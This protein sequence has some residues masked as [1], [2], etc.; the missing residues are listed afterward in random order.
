MMETTG[1]P[2]MP[3]FVF[4]RRRDVERE[5]GF[6]LA[7]QLIV[8]IPKGTNPKRRH[9]RMIDEILRQLTANAQSGQMPDDAIVY[10]WRGGC[11]PDDAVDVHNNALMKNWVS[12]RLVCAVR[13]DP[14]NDGYMRFDSDLLM[15]M[16]L[17][18]RHWA[19][20]K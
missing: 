4:I 15:K 1:Q 19:R 6:I 3:A 7:G 20:T 12:G 18:K 11:R 17:A 16:G 5:G 10:G 8:D 9:Q 14:R 13:V 2:I